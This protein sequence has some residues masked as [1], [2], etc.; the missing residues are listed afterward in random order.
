METTLSIFGR[1]YARTPCP[2]WRFPKPAHPGAQHLRRMLN[3]LPLTSLGDNGYNTVIDQFFMPLAHRPSAYEELCSTFCFIGKFDILS[4]R[5][6]ER[7]SEKLVT[8][9]QDD[10]EQRFSNE[11]LQ[12]LD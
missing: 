2:V 6:I 11:L 5:G 4:P 3:W 8:I 7:L 1:A 9:Y 12:F 10:L